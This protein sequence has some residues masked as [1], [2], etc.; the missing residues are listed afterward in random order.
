MQGREIGTSEMSHPE[1]ADALGDKAALGSA[2]ATRPS[3]APHLA[4][5]NPFGDLH[6][7]NRQ[8]PALLPRPV[9]DRPAG[10]SAVQDR[11][12]SQPNDGAL[13][14]D[15]LPEF[16]RATLEA[17]RHTARLLDTSAKWDPASRDES[18][19]VRRSYFGTRRRTSDA[20]RDLF[21]GRLT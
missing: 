12:V 3:L 17:L 8:L 9:R 6:V 19:G 7:R 1:R 5:S 10:R 14:L 21:D 11:E 2:W 16:D 4:S 18:C 20:Q 15:E 13:F